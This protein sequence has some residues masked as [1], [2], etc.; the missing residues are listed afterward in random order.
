[1]GRAARD[2]KRNRIA[3]FENGVAAAQPILLR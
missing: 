1:L 3:I 2:Y